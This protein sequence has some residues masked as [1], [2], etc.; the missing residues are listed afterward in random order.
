[1][2]TACKASITQSS[3]KQNPFGAWTLSLGNHL[4]HY[5]KGVSSI[6]IALCRHLNR[7][8]DLRISLLNTQACGTLSK[9][10]MEL[11][12]LQFF[13][14]NN[15]QNFVRTGPITHNLFNKRA[16]IRAPLDFYWEFTVKNLGLL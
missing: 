4:F 1:M 16:E 2:L 3:E 7:G 13:D 8:E 11:A 6:S 14:K 9:Q 15:S 12:F 10:T 5:H